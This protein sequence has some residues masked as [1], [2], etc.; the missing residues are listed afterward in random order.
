[1]IF[2]TYIYLPRFLLVIYEFSLRLNMRRQLN[3]ANEKWKTDR[4]DYVMYEN[5]FIWLIVDRLNKDR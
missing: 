1:M 5:K 2:K 3:Q 4:L